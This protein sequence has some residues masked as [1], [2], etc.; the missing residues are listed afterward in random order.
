MKKC[1]MNGTREGMARRG[2]L[3]A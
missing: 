2:T 3:S 1:T